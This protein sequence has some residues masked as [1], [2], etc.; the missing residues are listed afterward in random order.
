MT[1]LLL[2]VGGITTP[3]VNSG[4]DGGA[5]ECYIM[6]N[7]PLKLFSCAGSPH[8]NQLVDS[9]ADLMTQVAEND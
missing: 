1:S 5:Q 6:H 2:D 8:A 7:T 3:H 9:D 4:E